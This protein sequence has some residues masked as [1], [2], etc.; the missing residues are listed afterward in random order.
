[1]TGPPPAPVLVSPADPDAPDARELIAELDAALLVV[2]GR[3]GEA[4]FSAADVRAPRALF[5][6]ARDA[7]GAA[8]GCGAIRPLHGGVAEVKRMYARPG[9]QGVG[10][11]VLAHLER[12]AA[13]FGY[14]E[15]WLETGDVNTR[16]IDFYRRHG[17]QP[18]PNFGRYAGRS[19]SVCF[20]KRI[21]AAATAG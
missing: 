13:A 18:I 15:L 7:A 6:L 8:L 10:G 9:T 16:A 3:T 5:V 11:A 17:Y 1:M 21:A 12:A 4:S 19:E 2:A 14:T 20:G